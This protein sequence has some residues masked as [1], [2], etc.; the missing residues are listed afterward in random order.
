MTAR[1]SNNSKR[2]ATL[3]KWL[4]RLSVPL[5]PGVGVAELRPT[6]TTAEGK[7]VCSTTPPPYSVTRLSLTTRCA[8]A[9][10]AVCP[11]VA[12]GDGHRCLIVQTW[13]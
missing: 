8:A 9:L 3:F 4:L 2:N 12:P 7:S 11:T 6:L 13:P 5:P 10:K 1:E